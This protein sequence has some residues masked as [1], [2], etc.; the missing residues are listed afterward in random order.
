MYARQDQEMPSIIAHAAANM[1]S[2]PRAPSFRL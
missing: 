1:R 2:L